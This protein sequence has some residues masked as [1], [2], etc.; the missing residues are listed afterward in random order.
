LKSRLAITVFGLFVCWCGV[1]LS[2][3]PA[4]AGRQDDPVGGLAQDSATSQQKQPKNPDSTLPK[5]S[6]GK[7]RDARPPVT[8]EPLGPFSPLYIDP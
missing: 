1:A 4:K 5:K 3:T 7:E 2:A 8:A 6:S